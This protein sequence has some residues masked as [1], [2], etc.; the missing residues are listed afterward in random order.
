M[1]YPSHVSFN[2]VA[3]GLLNVWYKTRE[4][5]L[6]GEHLFSPKSCS[7]SPKRQDGHHGRHLQAEG[8]DSEAERF[9]ESNPEF[10]FSDENPWGIFCLKLKSM[11]H[12]ALVSHVIVSSQGHSACPCLVLQRRGRRM[13]Q[14]AGK[15]RTFCY[16]SAPCSGKTSESTSRT[17][18]LW[19]CY[20]TGT[21]L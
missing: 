9:Q 1:Y 21:A 8:M 16:P 13:W 10:K 7:F 14:P 20:Q 12:L 17:P 2:V 11:S 4:S 6:D 3:E 5:L 15:C 18:L 19:C